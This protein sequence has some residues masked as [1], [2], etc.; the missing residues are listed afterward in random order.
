MLTEISNVDGELAMENDGVDDSEARLLTSTMQLSN[1]EI[2]LRIA[3]NLELVGLYRKINEQILSE[4][5]NKKY[6]T[7]FIDI[8]ATLSEI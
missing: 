3:S 7:L 2:Y 4:K 1:K 8:T 6:P 5:G